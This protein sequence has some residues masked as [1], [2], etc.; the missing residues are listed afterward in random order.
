MTWIND[1]TDRTTTLA[2][3]PEIATAF[4]ALYASF[5]T[6]AHIAPETLELCRLRLAQLHNSSVDFGRE[7]CPVPAEKRETLSQWNKGHPFTEAEC[8]C[9]EFTEIYAMD[10]QAI[11]DEQ[12]EAVKKHYGDAG[13][14][15]L[16]EALGIFDGMTRL[17]LLWQLPAGDHQQSVRGGV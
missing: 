16:V 10:A 2:A 17:S 15:T 9:L 7:D 11:T 6:Q 1:G 14:I 5:W 12:A 4:D 3:L 8:A 13:L